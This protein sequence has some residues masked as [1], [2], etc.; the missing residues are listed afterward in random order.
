[1][2]IPE[3]ITGVAVLNG[4]KDNGSAITLS[5]IASFQ[6]ERMEG[7]HQ[8]GGY[9]IKDALGNTVSIVAFDEM[10]NITVDLIPSASTRAA[11]AALPTYPVPL[12]SITISNCL[13]NTTFASSAVAI[14]NGAHVYRG[15][16]RILQQS[17]QACKLTGVKLA[18]WAN[19]AQN[20]LLNT[21]VV[22]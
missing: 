13:I 4:V 10:G 2:I 3:V 19:S 22:G 16:A 1:M 20:A 11:A 7:E 18:N 17:G 9:E 6:L 15:G 5:Y 12:S 21:T 14:F 8:F